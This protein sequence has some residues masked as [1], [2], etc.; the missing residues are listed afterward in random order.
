M[1][2][3]DRYSPISLIRSSRSRSL[4]SRDSEPSLRRFVLRYWCIEAPLATDGVHPR[5]F[6]ELAVPDACA[7]LVIATREADRENSEIRLFWTSSGPFSMTLGHEGTRLFG[8]TFA[9]GGL[10]AL[11]RSPPEELAAIGTGSPIELDRR[12]ADSLRAIARA[13]SPTAMA[14]AADSELARTADGTGLPERLQNALHSMYASGGTLPV[15]EVARREGMS[16]RQLERLLRSAAGTTPKRL[17]RTLRFQ[18][19]LRCALG[20]RRPSW[21][22]LAMRFGFYD[23][24][25]LIDEFRFFSGL[26][27]DEFLHRTIPVSP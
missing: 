19:V 2:N 17:S 8:I 22:E 15:E 14:R 13:P 6:E 23:Q 21:V 26:S 3:V 16:R 24:S 10:A 1:A 5:I 20:P 11:T 12:W 25:H 18:S 9:P 27:P 7:D 4:L